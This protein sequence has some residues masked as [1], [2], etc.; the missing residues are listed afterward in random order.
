V[1]REELAERHLRRLVDDE[2]DMA[3]GADRARDED[4]RSVELVL[5]LALGD[6]DDRVVDLGRTRRRRPGDSADG[7]CGQEEC[8]NGQAFVHGAISDLFVGP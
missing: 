8:R 1:R 3:L 2:A 7:A 5:Q 6:Q 4:R